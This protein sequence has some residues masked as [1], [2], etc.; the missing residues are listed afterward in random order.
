MLDR[1]MIE[2]KLR[3][4]NEFVREIEDAKVG[5]SEEFRTNVV[6][7]RFVERN[8]ELALEQMLDICRHIVSGLDL[9]EPDTYA[10]CYEIIAKA[11]VLPTELVPTFQA[12]ARYRNMLIHIYD[13]VD[14][15]VT[16]EI[17]ANRLGDFRLFVQMI[18][19]Y[20]DQVS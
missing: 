8:I 5:S 19:N 1:D 13:S 2:R 6:V 17:F 12:M 11:G 10:E 20:L 15:T 14:D 9:K 3:R 7:K 18:R 4:I 16:Y